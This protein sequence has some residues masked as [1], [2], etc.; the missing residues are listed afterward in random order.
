MREEKELIV[1][2]RSPSLF[3]LLVYSRCREF[4]FSPDD[5]QT[6]TTVGRTP[7]EGGSAIHRDL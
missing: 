5:T 2:F 4:L 6:H 1:S 3:Y 7:L